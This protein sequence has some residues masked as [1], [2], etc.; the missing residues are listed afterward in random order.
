MGVGLCA[1]RRAVR[2]DIQS[3]GLLRRAGGESHRILFCRFE[4]AEELGFR[5]GWQGRFWGIEYF[6][7]S[8]QLLLGFCEQAFQL[9]QELFSD[10][11]VFVGAYKFW[12]L[13]CL[14]LERPAQT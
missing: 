1:G 8:K 2:D 10:R 6:Q 11:Y 5:I 4:P 14:H 3:E 12:R 9:F 7:N 13:V